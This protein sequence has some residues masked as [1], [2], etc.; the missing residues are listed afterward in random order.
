P[1]RDVV[2]LIARET[3]SEETRPKVLQVKRQSSPEAGLA[4]STRP[5]CGRGGR[6]RPRVLLVSPEAAVRTRWRRALQ[7]MCVIH[8]ESD[9]DA[10]PGAMGTLKPDVLLLDLSLPKL[11]R[12]GDMETIQQASP[13]TA[14]LVL[15]HAPDESQAMSVLKADARGYCS[16]R[17]DPKLLTKAF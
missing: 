6:G 10:L 5:G 17:I 7:K 13:G 3:L 12:G 15:A 11:R 1:G 16:A 9:R 8:E 4:R 14:V 2:A